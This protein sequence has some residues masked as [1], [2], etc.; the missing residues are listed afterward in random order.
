MEMEILRKLASSV[1][2]VVGL[3]LGEELP[4]PAEQVMERYP[5]YFIN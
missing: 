5:Y 1:G 3:I 2:D 4:V